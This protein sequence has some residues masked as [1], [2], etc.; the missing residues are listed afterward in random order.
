MWIYKWF[1]SENGFNVW[2]FVLKCVKIKSKTHDFVSFVHPGVSIQSKSIWFSVLQ[3][4]FHHN[5][6]FI[7]WLFLNSSTNREQWKD[8]GS[9]E[10]FSSSS[11]DCC[12]PSDLLNISPTLMHLHPHTEPNQYLWQTTQAWRGQHVFKWRDSISKASIHTVTLTLFTYIQQAMIQTNTDLNWCLAW[13]DKRNIVSL[14]GPINNTQIIIKPPLFNWQS[15]FISETWRFFL[16]SAIFIMHND[17][18]REILQ[19]FVWNQLLLY[20]N[21]GVFYGIEGMFKI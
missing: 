5:I 9:L 11:S 18:S 6:C 19:I 20:L 10:S 3:T 14:F 8:C 12:C 1:L 13:Y 4:A 2:Y 7:L 17:T 16:L 21:A 15:S